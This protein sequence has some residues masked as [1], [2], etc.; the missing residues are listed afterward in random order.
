[1]AEKCPCC[2]FY[3]LNKQEPAQGDSLFIGSFD[4]K[5]RRIY[6]DQGIMCDFYVCS[7]CGSIQLKAKRS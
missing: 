3:S 6:A 7:Q 2:G 1:M 4:S 5:A